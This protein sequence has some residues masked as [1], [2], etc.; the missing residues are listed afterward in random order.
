MLKVLRS[1]VCKQ[2]PFCD[3]PT[4]DVEHFACL[5]NAGYTCIQD[6]LHT[7]TIGNHVVRGHF[8]CYHKYRDVYTTLRNH[9]WEWDRGVFL[10]GRTIRE[11]AKKHFDFFLLKW[12]LTENEDY[13]YCIAG[14]TDGLTT[15]TTTRSKSLEPKV[16]AIPAKNS[17][18]EFWRWYSSTEPVV[19]I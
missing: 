6:Y 7:S 19:E 4:P 3:S 16:L 8:F 18:D 17:I 2:F 5:T 9:G 12:L 13:L 1:D 15:L 11:K 10:G 14:M